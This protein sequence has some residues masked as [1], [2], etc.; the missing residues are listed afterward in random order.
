M[1]NVINIGTGLKL[2][3]IQLKADESERLKFERRQRVEKG[4][5]GF[6][7]ITPEDLLLSEL[8]RGKRGQFFAP[9]K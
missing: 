3:L 4:G 7:I 8:A 1:F 9:G 5:V 6:W 2:D